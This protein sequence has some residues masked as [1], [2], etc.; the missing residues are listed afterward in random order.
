MK[1]DILYVWCYVVAGGLTMTFPL[2]RE[3]IST[4]PSD[5]SKVVAV[6]LGLVFWP[7]VV[8]YGLGRLF[9]FTLKIVAKGPRFFAK[10]V[11]DLLPKKTA[12]PKARVL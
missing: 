2:M 4:L 9:W 11:R 10:G 6:F 12:L 8:L 5:E 1:F 3:W 7:L